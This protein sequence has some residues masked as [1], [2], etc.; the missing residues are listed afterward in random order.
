M[1]HGVFSPSSTVFCNVISYY[2]L[3][4]DQLAKEVDGI[5]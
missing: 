3:K 1:D 2:P 5:D 4:K